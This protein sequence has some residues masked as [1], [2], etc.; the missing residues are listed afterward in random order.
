MPPDLAAAHSQD[1]CWHH[2]IR[3]VCAQLNGHF[4]RALR[5]SGRSGANLSCM[6]AFR[7]GA[8]FR[9]HAPSWILAP[10]ISLL[11]VVPEGVAS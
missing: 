1:R 8:T 3:V 9:P 2:Q 11:G 7:Q 10:H 6:H 5:V 4:D